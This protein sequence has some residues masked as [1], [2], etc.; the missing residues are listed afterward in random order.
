MGEHILFSETEDTR[1]HFATLDVAGTRFD[2]AVTYSQH[3]MGK[4]IVMCLQTGRASI[5]D[6]HDAEDPQRVAQ[7]FGIDDGET[8]TELGHYLTSVLSY[9]PRGEQF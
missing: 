6:A 9:P 8:A 1:T 4:S 2:L 7:H 5:M 3:F